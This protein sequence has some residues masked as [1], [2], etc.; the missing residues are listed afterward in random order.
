MLFYQKN[1]S[2]KTSISLT[3]QSLLVMALKHPEKILLSNILD[4]LDVY[5]GIFLCFPVC[6]IFKFAFLLRYFIC[7]TLINYERGMSV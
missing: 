1:P 7:L 6:F 5:W 4:K 3:V 2:S